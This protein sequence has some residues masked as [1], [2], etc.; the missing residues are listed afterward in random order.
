M[1]LTH[2][3]T[4]SAESHPRLRPS[5]FQEWNNMQFLRK[6]S[7]QLQSFRQDELEFF[8]SDLAAIT[9]VTEIDAD[10]D[11]RKV[12]LLFI[13]IGPKVTTEN[14]SRI[15]DDPQEELPQFRES[16][17]R[18][19][20]DS[21]ISEKVEDMLDWDAHIE[22]PPAPQ[23]SGTIKVIFKYIGRSKPIPVDDPWA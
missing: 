7:K 13:E 17:H 15:H 18:A 10:D 1:A 6:L 19:L 20:T 11:L 4:R 12:C 21:R 3:E 16:M 9:G 8:D 23:R 2:I 5:W 14:E 22:T